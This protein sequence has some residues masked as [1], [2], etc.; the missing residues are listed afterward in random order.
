[1]MCESHSS[2]THR[3]SAHFPSRVFDGFGFGTAPD[4]LPVRRNVRVGGHQV[5]SGAAAPRD[6]RSAAHCCLRAGRTVRSYDNRAQGL[7]CRVVARARGRAQPTDVRRS[8]SGASLGYMFLCCHWRGVASSSPDVGRVVHDSTGFGERWTTAFASGCQWG[9][10]RTRP[11]PVGVG[12]TRMRGCTHSQVRSS[13][14][15]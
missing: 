12:A 13:R 5:H 11:A 9:K 14:R 6:L 4:R 10:S 7:R 2:V 1:M 8:R 15:S 3:Q